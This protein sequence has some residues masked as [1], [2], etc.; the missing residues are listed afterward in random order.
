R[1]Q[2]DKDRAAAKPQ[3]RAKDARSDR[4][5]KCFYE[6]NNRRHESC[7]L[8]YLV[9][10]AIQERILH[11]RQAGCKAVRALL[12]TYLKLSRRDAPARHTLSV[13]DGVQINRGQSAIQTGVQID[14]TGG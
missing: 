4:D 10:P 7:L 1:Q 13:A 6:E 5:R 9:D 2:R 14:T 12:H 11:V 3:Q 8:A